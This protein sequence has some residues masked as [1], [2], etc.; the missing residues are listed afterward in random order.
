M[1]RPVVAVVRARPDTVVA[2]YARLLELAGAAAALSAGQGVLI[3]PCHSHDDYFPAV[4]SPP[5]QLDGVLSWIRAQGVAPSDIAVAENR[6]VCTDVLGVVRSHGWDRVLSRH[7]VHFHPLPD[8]PRS[9]IQVDPSELLMDWEPVG[10]PTLPELARGRTLVHLVPLKVHGHSIITGSM[11]AAFNLVLPWRRC[12]L[13]HEAIHEALS[14]MLYLH[15]HVRQQPS[16]GIIDGVWSGTGRGPVTLRPRLTELLLA[17]TDL[18]ALDAV[19]ARLMGFDPLSIPFV[20]LSHERGLGCADLDRIEL[21]G[22][23]IRGV[24]LGYRSKLNLVLFTDQLLRRRLGGAT[25][26]AVFDSPV[27]GLTVAASRL[28]HNGYWRYLRAPRRRREFDR[29]PWAE[30]VS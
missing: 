24:D 19:A 3:K 15:Q 10:G 6:T 28:Y 20:R 9:P 12:H 13:A 4:S 1:S 2:D 25:R 22:E 5:W 7:G 23:D 27:E 21:V 16:I 8:A 29:S 11:K 18:V 14:D 26:Q 17:S 30:W